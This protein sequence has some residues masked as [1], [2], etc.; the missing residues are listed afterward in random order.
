MGPERTNP[1][2]KKLDKTDR[3]E[4]LIKPELEPKPSYLVVRDGSELQ[5]A[6]AE[7]IERSELLCEP[8]H[9]VGQS[10]PTGEQVEIIPQSPVDE[11]FVSSLPEGREFILFANTHDLATKAEELRQP[12][13]DNTMVIFESNNRLV[14][15]LVASPEQRV[16]E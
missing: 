13:A 4:G 3:R 14:D 12:L 15:E 16:T 7:K 6:L 8:I 11:K 9:K 1:L 2:G 10:K 5:Q